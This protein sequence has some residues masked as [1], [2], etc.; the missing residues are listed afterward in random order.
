MD[1]RDI[2]VAIVGAGASGLAAAA[3][4]FDAGLKD[5]VV[6]EAA[7]RIGGRQSGN[8]VVRR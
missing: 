8:S 7:D 1:T 3:A 6:V 2:S 4:L 5:V